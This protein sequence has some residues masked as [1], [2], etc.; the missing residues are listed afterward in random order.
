MANIF[1]MNN[2]VYKRRTGLE[3][4]KCPLHP[5]KTSS[6]LVHKQQCSFPPSNLT[7]L[8]MNFS[9]LVQFQTLKRFNRYIHC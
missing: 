2:E 1:G 4:A 3:T 7:I 6:T 5:Y 8:M 9:V